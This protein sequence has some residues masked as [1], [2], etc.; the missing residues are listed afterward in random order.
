[1]ATKNL[2]FLYDTYSEAGLVV[3]ELETAGIPRDDISIVSNDP[4]HRDRDIAREPG[5]RTK[6][7]AGI[8]AAIGGTAGA[9]AGL[10]TGLGLLAIPGIGP[11]V[12]AGWLVST[13][14]VGAVGAATGGLIGSLTGA[15]L[16]EEHAHAYAE[17]VR[18]GGTLVTARVDEAR[19]STAE[20]IMRRHNPRDPD[21]LS[22]QYRSTGWTGFDQNADTSSLTQTSAAR[23]RIV[24]TFENADRARAARDALLADGIAR[25]RIEIW[26]DRSG[27]DSWST[28]KN[29]SVPDEDCHLYAESLGRGHA[30]LLIRCDAGEHDRMLQLIQGYHPID[31][32]EHAA[33]WRESG[34]SGRAAGSEEQVIPVYEEKL[35]VGKRVVE[36]SGVRVRV[37]TVAEPVE[38]GVT[39]RRERVEVQ[40]RPVDRPVGST[41]SDAFQERTIDVQTRQEEPVISKE[42][43]IKEEIV[44]RKEADQKNQTV[45]DSVRR[46]QV[47]VEGAGT[48]P[49]ESGSLPKRK[50]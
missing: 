13:L 30:V 27:T 18:R 22:A 49:P 11:V 24:A 15:G 42:A 47:E 38:E 8:G 32:D 36:R 7:G 6:T 28:M 29:W 48:T 31:I 20:A 44:V 33:K 45:G 1:M 2:T 5:E 12:A 3:S 37:Y 50:E 40:R 9:T 17:G 16:S 35:R 4:A 10:L 19:A 34:W 23:D 25:D 21:Q 43:Q 39:L 46:T 26:D 14:A 41:H